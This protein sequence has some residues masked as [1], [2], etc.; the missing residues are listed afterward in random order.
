MTPD[1]STW[2]RADFQAFDAARAAAFQPTP[3]E[4]SAQKAANTARRVAV[5]QGYLAKYGIAFT[6][7]ETDFSG[8]YAQYITGTPDMKEWLGAD[9]QSV[10]DAN[11]ATGNA[12]EPF[13]DFILRYEL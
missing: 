6:G 11:V 8:L 7:Q 9:L 4:F 13:M 3:E 10:V 2:T 1:F 5:V 12:L